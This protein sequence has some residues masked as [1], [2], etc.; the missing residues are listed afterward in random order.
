MAGH[1]S[2]S[3]GPQLPAEPI[4]RILKPIR[5]FLHIEASSGIVLLLCSIIALVIANSSM[6]EEYAA[7]WKTKVGLTWGDFSYQH[8]LKHWINDG[9]MVI[10]FFVIGLEVKRE[11]V[12]GELRDF[13][14]AALPISAAIGGMAI[15]ALAYYLLQPEPPQQSGWGIPMATDIAFV[16]GCI[17]VLGSRI[18]PILRVLL[19]SL[20]IVDDIGAILVI[21]FGYTDS[22]ETNW[23][24]LGLVSAAFVLVLQR[25]GVRAIPVY[26]V[27]GVLTWLGFHES[28]I[29]ATIAGVIIGLLTPARPY[30]EA[31]F[32]GAFLNQASEF[33]H[34]EREEDSTLPAAKVRAYR[35]TTLEAISPLEYLIN[36]LHT[37][38]AFLIM[39]IFALANAGVVFQ[40]NDIV[41]PV[42]VAITAS[43]AIGKPVGVVLFSWI[44]TRL[45]L[46]KL[47][48]GITWR[49]L[50][51]GGCL[52]GIGFT[53][54]LFISGLAFDDK[55]LLSSAKVGVLVGSLISAV[56]GLSVLVSIPRPVPTES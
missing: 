39:P 38:V 18:P 41:S 1:S 25:L 31:S 52:A 51:G 36:L 44:A 4:H 5:K 37:W 7:F 6:G 9:L 23:L 54:A 28:G 27:V 49:H 20:A 15:P 32:V 55:L 11:L 19:L 14:R 30:L 45:G 29:H 34:G 2:E 3:I 46:A 53:M 16:V 17:A 12:F 47:P 10:F 40:W 22:I 35:Q 21:A 8:S 13:R 43:L 56:V 48:E 24:L 33:L 26:V 50:I 42:A